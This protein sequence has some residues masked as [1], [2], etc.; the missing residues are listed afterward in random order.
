VHVAD[1]STAADTRARFLGAIDA[2]RP[3]LHRFCA[4]MTGSALDGEDVVQETLAQA[5]D[6][7]HTLE[8][9]SRLEPWLFRIAHHRCVDLLRRERRQ[10]E[11]MVPYTADHEPVPPHHPALD[12]TPIDEAL[13]ALVGELPPKER[14][15]V[16]LKDVLDYRLH[17]IAEIVDSTV[18]GVKTALH[19]ARGKLRGG[20]GTT[21]LP[22]APLDDDGRRLLEAYAECFNRR[23][24]VALSRLVQADA[25][26]EIVG[27]SAGTMRD[28]LG[29]NYYGNYAKRP[30]E[31]RVSLAQVDGE[32]VLVHWRRT[33][34]KDS[35]WQ[36]VNAARIWCADGRIVRI[37]DYV[38]VH[39]LLRDARITALSPD[40]GG[41]GS[42]VQIRSG[43]SYEP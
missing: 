3:R 27:V 35:E 5:F 26:L 19:R 20:R 12:D 25:R 36:P 32:P 6:A 28:V 38:H 42:D 13:A 14:A 22:S 40:G 4:R 17:E 30:W 8:H 9:Q 21:P 43:E 41:C 24:W 23:D 10:L 33:D 16:L 1:D 2:L 31:W 37:R 11:D 18:G 15:A 7:L 34:V 29:R 39:Y